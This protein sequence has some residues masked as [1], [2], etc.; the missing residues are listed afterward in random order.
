[1]YR[2]I[3]SGTLSPESLVHFRRN[4]WYTLKRNWWYT[5]T[6]I[7]TSLIPVCSCSAIPLVYSL[8]GKI[9]KQ[10]LITFIVAAPLLNPY[11]I[12]LSFSVLGFEYGILRIV[13]S[14][15]LAISTGYL[16]TF[17]DKKLPGQNI[18]LIN[19]DNNDC[20]LTTG[21]KYQKTYNVFKK[22]LPYLA[23]AAV[24]GIIFEYISPAEY[25]KDLDLNQNLIGILLVTLVGIPVYFCNGADVLFLS[26]LVFYSGLPLGTAMAFSLTSTSVCISSIAMMLKFIGRKS[27]ILLL[28]NVIIVTFLLAYIINLLF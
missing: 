8:E 14:F 16:L 21:D 12:I 5:F 20:N 27:T 2:S 15:I 28:F 9:S 24:L 1:D 18:P 4:H 10:T 22:I 3:F 13:S 6:G 11:I 25:I 26:P 7:C 23:F 17:A 19:C